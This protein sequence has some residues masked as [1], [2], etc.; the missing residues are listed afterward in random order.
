MKTKQL[1]QPWNKITRKT[2]LSN[3]K[4]LSTE[5][6]KYM[7]KLY[8]LLPPH[9]REFMDKIIACESV[10]FVDDVDGFSSEDYVDFDAD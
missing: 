7:M 6:K 8:D 10:D 5:K 1:S 4:P 2:L 3:G 9:G